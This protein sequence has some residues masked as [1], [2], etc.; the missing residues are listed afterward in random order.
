MA[1]VWIPIGLQ[2]LAMFVDELHFHRRRQ[3][4]R[5]ERLGHPLDTLSVLVCYAFA[6]SVPPSSSALAVYAALSAI[7]CLLVTKDEFV[8][9]RLCPPA[10]QWLHAILFVL[11]PVVLGTFAWLWL[12]GARTVLTVQ[13][14]VTLMFGLYQFAYWNLSWKRTTR[15][16]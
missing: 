3:L 9:S 16:R 14:V 7:S 12:E 10:E 5:W 15:A 13:A 1:W 11:H 6:L 8:H 2:A 4:P